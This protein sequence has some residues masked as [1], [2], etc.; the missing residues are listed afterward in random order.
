MKSA[1]A[2]V[3]MRGDMGGAAAVL[4]A[5]EVV[6]SRRLPIDVT[7][8]VA[9]AANLVVGNYPLPDGVWSSP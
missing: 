3:R 2:M 8:G 7:A 4:A 1:D 5:I 6:A 9:A